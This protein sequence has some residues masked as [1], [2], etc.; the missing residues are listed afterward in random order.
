MNLTDKIS[1]ELIQWLERHEQD[2]ALDI[3]DFGDLRNVFL[4]VIGREPKA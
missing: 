4:Y 1:I 2:I 3:E